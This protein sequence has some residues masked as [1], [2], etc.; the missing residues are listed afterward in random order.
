MKERFNTNFIS[1]NVVFTALNCFKSEA[2]PNTDS[3][4]EN[5]VDYK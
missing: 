5:T 1:W 4:P 3:K 2:H